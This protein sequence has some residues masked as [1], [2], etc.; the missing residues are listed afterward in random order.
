[1]NEH[2]EGQPEWFPGGNRLYRLLL[3][4]TENSPSP[5]AIASSSTSPVE[6]EAEELLDF[7]SAVLVR[8]GFA[9]DWEITPLGDDIETL[10]DIVNHMI[11]ED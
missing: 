5:H 3:E 1:M 7:L 6:D 8:R 11:P 2:E 10:I 9:G 4:L